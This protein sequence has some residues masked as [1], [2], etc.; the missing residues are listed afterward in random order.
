MKALFVRLHRFTRV[1]GLIVLFAGLTAGLTL[2][3]MGGL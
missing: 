1:R 2:L 3:A